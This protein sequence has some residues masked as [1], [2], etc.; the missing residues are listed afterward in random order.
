[1]FLTDAGAWELIAEHLDAGGTFYEMK[2]DCPSGAPAIWFEMG[3]ITQQPVYVKVQIGIRNIAIGR[4][5]HFV[6]RYSGHT[7]EHHAQRYV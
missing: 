1:M 2:L 7:N 4:S 3:V 6:E 5:F